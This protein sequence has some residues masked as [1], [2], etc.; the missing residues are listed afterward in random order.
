MTRDTSRRLL[1]YIRVMFPPGRM[2]ATGAAFFLSVYLGL[3]AVAG[4]TPVTLGWPAVVGIASTVL[5]MLLVRLSD[6]LTDAD[7]DRRLAAAGDSRFRHRPTVTGAVTKHDLQRLSKMAL[8]ALLG[9]N[10]T[11]G[12]SVA[13]AGCLIGW[14]VTWLGFHWFFVDR[15]ARNPGPLAYL[16]RKGLTVLVAAYA[17]AVY[18][19][20]AGWTLTWWT[21]PLLLAPCAGVAAWEV[22]R[23][24]RLPDDET[25]YGTYSNAVGWRGATALAGAFVAASWI[26][27]LLVARAA[28]AGTV[29][30]TLLSSAALL[31]IGACAR[32]LLRP[33]R[34]RA[35]LGPWMQLYGAATHGGLALFLTLRHRTVFA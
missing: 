24:I 23:K 4:A 22:G 32:M 14:V 10:V 21:V 27:L 35:R 19:D 17:A 25:A 31:A 28:Q 16:A 29:Y 30:A 8:A 26:A 1:A 3:Q 5:W 9:L 2:L 13:L 7:A 12:V 20:Q 34:Q 18:V 15:W 6:D 11:L 33:T